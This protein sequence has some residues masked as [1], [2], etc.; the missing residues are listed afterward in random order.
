MIIVVLFANMPASESWRDY[1]GTGWG[2]GSANRNWR[3]F[4]EDLQGPTRAPS[5]AS[6]ILQNNHLFTPITNLRG[7]K[8]MGGTFQR[9]GQPADPSEAPPNQQ[10]TLASMAKC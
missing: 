2:G 10:F 6:L 1:T 4:Q 7:W 5:S 8:K 9:Q 3:V